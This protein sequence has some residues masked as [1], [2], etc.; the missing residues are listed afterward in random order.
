[1]RRPR[2]DI[3]DLYRRAVAYV[4][5]RGGA[6]IRRGGRVGGGTGGNGGNI[7]DRFD[8]SKLYGLSDFS[9][10]NFFRTPDSGGEAGVATGFGEVF[11]C[12]IRGIDPAAQQFF[13]GK[14]STGGWQALLGTNGLVSAFLWSTSSAFTQASLTLPTGKLGRLCLLFVQHTGT[15][16][17]VALDRMEILGSAAISGFFPANPATQWEY[18]GVNHVGTE[19]STK[20]DHLARMAFRGVPSDTQLIALAD[21]V[22]ANGDFPATFPQGVA[23]DADIAALAPRHWYRADTFTPSGANLGTLTNRNLTVGGA[24]SVISGTIVQP[25]ADAALNGQFSVAFGGT[26]AMASSFA[27]AEFRFLHQGPMDVFVVWVPDAGSSRVLIATQTLAG[28]TETGAALWYADSTL[29]GTVA[30]GPAYIINSGATAAIVIGVGGYAEF[31]YVNDGAPEFFYTFGGQVLA[32]GADNGSAPA[33]GD[34]M[35]T[36]TVGSGTGGAAALRGRIADILIFNRRLA[37]SERQKVRDYIRVRYAIGDVTTT[38][39]WSLREVLRA[40]N[41]R[42]VDGQT[43]PASLPDTI[44]AATIDS[45]NRQGAP[46]VRLVDPSVE[47]RRSY[48]ILGALSTSYL[49]GA[50]L[51]RTAASGYWFALWAI[52]WSIAAN[53]QSYKWLMDFGASGKSCGIYVASGNSLVVQGSNINAP[54]VTLTSLQV[55]L[56]MLITGVMRGAAIEAYING[57]ST[58]APAA[59]TDAGAPSLLR[60]GANLVN[61]AWGLDWSLFGYAMGRVAG[62]IT[63]QEVA[64]HYA[65]CVR[66]GRIVPIVGKTEHYVDLTQDVVA[67]GPDNGIPVQALDRIGTDHLTKFGGYAVAFNGLQD[68]GVSQAGQP[69]V[70]YARA[71]GRVLSGNTSGWWAESLTYRTSGM[72]AGQSAATIFGEADGSLST[73]GWRFSEAGGNAWVQVRANGATQT[74][75]TAAWLTPGLNHVAVRY[76]GSQFFCYLNGVLRVTSAAGMVYEPATTGAT[77]FGTSW[78]AGSGT[79]SAFNH[80]IRG[81]SGGNVAATDAEIVAAANTALSTGKVVGV[82]G[83]T[84]VL[85]SITD[86]I[87]EAGGRV[88]SV[89]RERIGGVNNMFTVNG[90]LQ[91]AQV[92]EH[93]WSYE[94]SPILQGGQAWTDAAYYEALLGKLLGEASGF[95]ASVLG[96]I[97]SQAV[98]SV[99]RRLFAVRGFGNPGWEFATTGTNSSVNFSVGGTNSQISPA[100][101][102]AASDVGR[103]FLFTG[104]WDAAANVVRIYARRV[105][106]GSGSS[107]LVGGFAPETAQKPTIGRRG[108]GSPA[109]GVAIYGVTYAPGIASLAQIQAQYDAVMASERIQGVPGLPGTVIDLTTDIQAA[110]GAMPATLV[111]RGTGGV[112]FTRIGNPQLAPMY[113]RAWAA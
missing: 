98:A 2:R 51:S 61:T 93:V 41:H 111:D 23:G 62:G 64:D 36:L 37:E 100:V 32:V 101:T 99:G 11:L 88:P 106:Q 77:A 20:I 67:N 17:R 92:V 80:A 82:P 47:G 81:G 30:N 57:V 25:A 70:N 55:G 4:D 27:P 69:S 58:G 8:T 3:H 5:R 108:V 95:T 49:E 76:D 103:L 46:T 54:A 66:A 72:I 40:V 21:Y 53:G 59:C 35:G 73:G 107:P 42:V 68:A 26:Q 9:A 79:Y 44:T 52:P 97:T 91:V 110:G 75:S 39:R 74:F 50:S 16:V 63:A 112:N 87:A 113:S 90:A 43:A 29:R 22:R 12:R 28:G 83:K 102:I 18:W 15:S 65:A 13:G 48:G 109:D 105:Q 94:T 86:D 7:G 33:A 60:L 6:G 24:L 85:W 96:V 14:R 45:M 19:P 84:A 71:V 31:S 78:G 34:P 1:M 104:V 56:P 38:H 89:L 10:A